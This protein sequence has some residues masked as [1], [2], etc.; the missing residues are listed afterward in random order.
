MKI[1]IHEAISP[2]AEELLK[3]GEVELAIVN[4]MFIES[5]PYNVISLLREH[6]YVIGEEN[7]PLFL[8]KSLKIQD[9]NGMEVAL[10]RAYEKTVLE[11]CQMRGVSIHIP[12]LTSS[13]MGA[14]CFA[15]MKGIYAIA[16][17]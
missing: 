10:P 17:L 12:V 14:I 9:L 3:N 6:F 13:T 4:P 7:S 1:A 15:L 11:Y 2:K 16:P 8:K 5:E